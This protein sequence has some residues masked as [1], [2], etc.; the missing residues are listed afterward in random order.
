MEIAG[1]TLK[2]KFSFYD[3]QHDMGAN[4]DWEA[5]P[6]TDHWGNDL[7][8][9]SYLPV[10]V[11]AT[12]ESGDDV[13]SRK[14]AELVYDWVSKADV[15]DSWFWYDDNRPRKEYSP[16]VWSSYLNIAIH[17]N[18]WATCFDHLIR[19]WTPVQLID[20]LKSIHD[21]LVYLELVI[22]TMSN[23]WIVIGTNG[24]INTAARLP[25][26]R[27]S[28]RL[29]D[30][31]L[32]LTAAEANSQVLPDGVQF[33]LT[34]HYHVGVTNWLCS[35]MN[36]CR[37]IS[38]PVPDQIDSAT[39]KM[40]DYAMHMTTP[41]GK[42]VAFNDSDP[43]AVTGLQRLLLTE[44]RRR[45]RDDWIYVA[46]E[47]DE[48]RPPDVLS[49]S[50]EYGGVYTMRTGWDRDDILLVFDGGPWGKSHQH[51]DRL[52]FWLSAYGRSL[53]VDPGRYMYDW[54]NP[55]SGDRYL[56]TSRAHNTITVD[57]QGQADRFFKDTW[58]PK[59]RVSGN[60][61]TRTDAFQR[62]AGAHELGYGED[63]NIKA[64]H[65]RSITYFDAGVFLV[66]DS[67]TGEGEHL[68]ESRL[69]LY[70]G[71]LLEDDGIW[72]TNYDDAN[73]AIFPLMDKPF[74]VKTECGQMD[75]VSGWY[76]PKVN[77]IEPAP[78][79][80]VS[81]Q[82]PLPLRG[83]FLIAPYRGSKIPTLSLS[84]SN[85]AA[86]VLCGDSTFTVDFDEAML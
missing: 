50:F 58:I 32:E 12:H 55:F 63:G 28:R 52:S 25:E 73:M 71:E 6:G 5:N 74:T 72:H 56:K 86:S 18:Q 8:R 24:V 48:G 20:I 44:G 16:Y 78:T 53:I 37:Q 62:V 15:C 3:E 49:K 11:A 83:A 31:A 33:E 13:Y 46:T 68:V 40:T 85:S 30:Y 21:Q 82:T 4:I 60:T 84:L 7:N 29:I 38:V 59:E 23:N 69:H 51:D 34:Q 67:V 79:M 41:D 54:N 45:K 1:N 22:P 66:L 47:G 36:V 77:H 19:F 17:L 35:I 39:E 27:D 43:E 75:P 65:R 26:L 64:V 80:T 70:P 2:N 14:A 10:L 81:A 57:G 42:L 76:S 61:V 9:F